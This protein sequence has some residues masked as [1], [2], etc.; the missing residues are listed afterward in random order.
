LEDFMRQLRCLTGVSAALL[1]GVLPLAPLRGQQED[2]MK[3]A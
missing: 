1:L 3:K 2:A